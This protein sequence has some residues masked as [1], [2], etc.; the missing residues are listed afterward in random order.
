MRETDSVEHKPCGLLAHA[1]RPVK[2]P[3]RNAILAIGDKPHSRKPLVQ[4]E[5]GILKD[6][7]G[8]D[9]ELAQRVMA[10]ALPSLVPVHKLHLGATASRAGYAIG[11]ALPGEVAE[12]VL[13]I[14]VVHDCGLKRGRPFRFHASRLPKPAGLAKFINALISVP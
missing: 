12:A 4:A 14:G 6:G 3:G 2:F 11:P 13:G 5:R 10:T 7:P 1:K 9:G 8:F